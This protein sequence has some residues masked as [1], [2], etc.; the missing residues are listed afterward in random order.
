MPD[1]Q[2]DIG[3]DT[4]SRL[5]VD[6]VVDPNTGAIIQNHIARRSAVPHAR[7]PTSFR[8]N[9]T[10]ILQQQRWTSSLASPGKAKKMS[11]AEPG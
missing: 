5:A 4:L 6:E 2:L 11:L 7:A 8:D 9:V 1:G 3:P 10:K